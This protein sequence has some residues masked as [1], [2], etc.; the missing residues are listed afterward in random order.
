M[1]K[2]YIGTYSLKDKLPKFNTKPKK[3]KKSTT[4]SKYKRKNDNKVIK[5]AITMPNYFK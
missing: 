5:K 4:V 3:A 2:D 1:A